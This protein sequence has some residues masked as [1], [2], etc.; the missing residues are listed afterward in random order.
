MCPPAPPSPA[1]Q[2]SLVQRELSRPKTATEGLSKVAG[3]FGDDL[4]RAP[5]PPLVM[6]AG[7]DAPL[8][9]TG[10]GGRWGFPVFRRGRC[11]HR[12]AAAHPR[13]TGRGGALS[14]PVSPRGDG[15]CD[16]ICR[17]R[18]V[19]RPVNGSREEACPGGHIGPPLREARRR[20]GTNGNRRENGPFPAGRGGA[21]PLQGRRRQCAA[22]GPP[23]SSAP[24]PCGGE[25]RRGAPGAWLPPLRNRRKTCW[26][27][28]VPALRESGKTKKHPPRRVLFLLR[29]WPGPGSW[30]R[31]GPPGGSRR[32]RGPSPGGRLP[33]A[34]GPRPASA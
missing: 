27:G 26:V 4:C 32:S 19:C 28:T 13:S 7:A 14:P 3:Y 5:N 12:P 18:P 8:C 22:S 20:S 29:R 6:T 15:C 17:G 23:G 11:P 34:P 30:Q 31:R 24:T 33:G 1:G 10:P 9:A 16:R 25:G 21:R 2:G